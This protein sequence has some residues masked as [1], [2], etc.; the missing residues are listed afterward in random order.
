MIYYKVFSFV[1][2]DD[3]NE[4][5]NIVGKTFKN[6][7]IFNNCVINNESYINAMDCLEEYNYKSDYAAVKFVQVSYIGKCQNIDE[8]KCLEK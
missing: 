1:I 8:K 2:R 6:N 7:V 4:F 3:F 5:D